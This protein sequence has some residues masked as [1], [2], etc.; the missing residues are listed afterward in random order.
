MFI[1]Q[2]IYKINVNA[3]IILGPYVHCVQMF[4]NT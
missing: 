1:T 3:Q 2:N 4:D